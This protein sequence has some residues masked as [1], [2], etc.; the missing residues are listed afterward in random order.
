MRKSLISVSLGCLKRFVVFLDA[1]ILIVNKERVRVCVLV[2]LIFLT[3][4]CLDYFQVFKK[5][6]PFPLTLSAPSASLPCLS[7]LLCLLF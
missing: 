2:N 3:F 5:F 1:K 4:P 7:F 6:S